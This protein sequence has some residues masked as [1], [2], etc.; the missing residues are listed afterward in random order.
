MITKT[1]DLKNHFKLI[2]FEIFFCAQIDSSALDFKKISLGWNFKK[3]Y[4]FLKTN[5]SDG[6]TKYR[7]KREITDLLVVVETF[8]RQ[9]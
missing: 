6:L 8:E 3:S 2:F 7:R 9:L 5:K 1:Q 4:E